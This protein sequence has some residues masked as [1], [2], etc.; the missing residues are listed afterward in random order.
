MLRR[1]VG[2][3][4]TVRI[5]LHTIDRACLQTGNECRTS[6]AWNRSLCRINVESTRSDSRG[7][8]SRDVVVIRH[9]EEGLQWR[10]EIRTTPRAFLS[11]WYRWWNHRLIERQRGARHSVG[12]RPAREHVHEIIV[13]TGNPRPPIVFAGLDPIEFVIR[14]WT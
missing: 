11:L 13:V 10:H 7:S 14:I 12:F 9:R 1:I 5:E 4:G 3:S 2:G 8:L 6:P